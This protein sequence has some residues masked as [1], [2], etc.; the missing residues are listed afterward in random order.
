MSLE[1]EPPSELLNI[2][3]SERPTTVLQ[4]KMQYAGILVPPARFDVAEVR[5]KVLPERF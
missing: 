4:F 1:Y 2:S 3:D 5:F